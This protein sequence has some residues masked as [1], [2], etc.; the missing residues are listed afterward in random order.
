MLLIE[1]GESTLEASTRKSV[2]GVQTHSEVDFKGRTSEVVLALVNRAGENGT[3]P[4]EIAAILLKQK[5]MKKGSNLVHSQLSELK[6]KGLI[7]K[8]S[9]G[10]YFGF[11]ESTSPDPRGVSVGPAKNARKKRKL[12]AAGREA[13]R[14]AQKARW[15]AVKKAK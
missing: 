8:K 13:I 12:T 6:K 11:S 3:R 15:A 14:K 9:D 5:L 7:R 1:T 10:L 2:N 4:R